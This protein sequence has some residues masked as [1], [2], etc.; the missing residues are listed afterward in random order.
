MIQVSIENVS[1]L[2]CDGCASLL[3]PTVVGPIAD[4]LPPELKGAQVVH[5]DAKAMI[6]EAERRLATRPEERT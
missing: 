4:V 6:A 1:R 2:L 3:Y 5:L